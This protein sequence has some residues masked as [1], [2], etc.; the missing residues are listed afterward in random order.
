MPDKVLSRWT[1]I[2]LRLPE[3]TADDHHPPHRGFVVSKKN[4]AWYV[5]N[6]HNEGR[7]ALHVRVGPGQNAE[8]VATD[9]DRFG[10]PK[11]VARHGWVTYYL[12]LEDRPPDW[13]E[14]TELV[15]DSYRIQASKRLARLVD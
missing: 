6:E 12:D 5:D 13:D 4:F 10:L 7:I 2:C 3:A 9:G 8:L 11:Y 1:P 14:I 15:T